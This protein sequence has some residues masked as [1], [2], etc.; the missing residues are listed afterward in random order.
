MST[1]ELGNDLHEHRP[2]LV[3]APSGRYVVEEVPP[4][5]DLLPGTCL[6]AL[7][8]GTIIPK[9][10]GLCERQPDGIRSKWCRALMS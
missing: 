6:K 1:R 3:Q 5:H 10:A 7:D 9:T 2:A 4:D 8:R